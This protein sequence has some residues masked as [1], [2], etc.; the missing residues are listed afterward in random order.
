MKGKISERMEQEIQRRLKQKDAEI[1]RLRERL[2]SEPVKPSPVSGEVESD[3]VKHIAEIVGNLSYPV[4]YGIRGLAAEALH[5]YAAHLRSPATPEPE[6]GKLGLICMWCYES[7]RDMAC[8]ASP[9][10]HH[11]II[12]ADTLGGEPEQSD[13]VERAWQA[14]AELEAMLQR[15]IDAHNETKDSQAREIERLRKALEEIDRL[16]VDG[17]LWKATVRGSARRALD[18][19][20]P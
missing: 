1:T 20:Q 9:H 19:E 11:T 10:G 3:R 16:T 12:C 6:Q 18:G 17:V 2:G 5:A 15:E 14:H 7:E 8:A 4:T 13:E